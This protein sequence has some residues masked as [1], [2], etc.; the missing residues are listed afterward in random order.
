MKKLIV[1]I[2]LSMSFCSINAQINFPPPPEV[3][4]LGK[5]PFSALKGNADFAWFDSGVMSYPPTPAYIDSLKKIKKPYTLY[6]LGGTWCE[7]TQKLLPQLYAVLK[8]YGKNVD[9]EVTLYFVDRD[10][11]SPEGTE[12][13]YDL[14]NVPTIIVFDK[15][16]TEIGRIVES[17][18]VSVEADLLQILKKIK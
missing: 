18:K 10:K 13:K 17:V 2:F 9:T 11:K 3:M 1:L 5:Q 15:T 6:V 16:N 12:S 14:K 7:D 4:L 8:T